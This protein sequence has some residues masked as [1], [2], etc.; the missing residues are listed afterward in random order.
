MRGLSPFFVYEAIRCFG[1]NI[2]WQFCF[3]LYIFKAKLIK[4][5]KIYLRR[6]YFY[7]E[8]SPFPTFLFTVV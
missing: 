1:Q 6:Y 4:I 3:I 5:S 7:A 8:I 2:D